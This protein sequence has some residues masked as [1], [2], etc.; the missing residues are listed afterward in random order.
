MNLPA[1]EI[2]RSHRRAQQAIRDTWLD[3]RICPGVQ[4]RLTLRVIAGGI[5]GLL[6]AS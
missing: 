4:L 2:R 5:R 3:L 1:A 6:L